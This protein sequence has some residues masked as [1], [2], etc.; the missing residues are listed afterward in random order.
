MALGPGLALASPVQVGLRLVSAVGVV[1]EVPIVGAATSG[2]GGAAGKAAEDVFL[3]RDRVHSSVLVRAAGRAFAQGAL[4]QMT[5][6]HIAG[7]RA[8]FVRSE[9]MV[10]GPS[11]GDT[12]LVTPGYHR[13][14]PSLSVSWT[15][16]FKGVRVRGSF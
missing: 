10:F 2:L 14:K 4:S 16:A 15:G 1:T 7:P 9:R 11:M 3:R 5:H 13:G 12:V 8:G 6:A